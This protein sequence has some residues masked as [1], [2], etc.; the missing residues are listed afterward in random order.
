MTPATLAALKGSI[1][2]WEGIVAG[3]HVDHGA[4][5]CPLCAM[6]LI[7]KPEISACK[8]CP[9]SERTGR[10]GCCGTP[11]YEFMRLEARNLDDDTPI[12][13]ANP[14]HAL[15]LAAAQAMLAFLKDLLPAGDQ[16]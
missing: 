16:P 2:K 10:Y 15:A 6:F 13:P 5:D 1:A 9:I 4:L 7:E 11:Y 12:D 8:G 3:T 14:D